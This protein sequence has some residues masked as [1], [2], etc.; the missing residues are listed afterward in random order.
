MEVVK[1]YRIPVNAPKDLMEEY[2]KVKRRALE[3]VLSRVG[4]SGKA[5]LSFGKRR[6]DSLET[7][8]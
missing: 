1:S 8:C 2:L 3:Y 7:P 4:L 6:G 5:H